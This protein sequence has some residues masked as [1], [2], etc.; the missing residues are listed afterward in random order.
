MGATNKWTLFQKN[1]SLSYDHH[2]TKGSRV[3]ALDELM[4]NEI[5]SIFVLKIQNRIPSNIYFGNLFTD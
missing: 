4:S 3:I 2:K 1:G 5:Y